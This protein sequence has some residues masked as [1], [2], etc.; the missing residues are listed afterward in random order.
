MELRDAKVLVTGG[1][2]GIGLET[3]RQL[4]SRGAKVSICGRD[5][6]RVARAGE[7]LGCLAIPAD[8]SFGRRSQAWAGSTCS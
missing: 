7:E 8:V 3:A 1:S 5:E 6:E 4:V 2:A